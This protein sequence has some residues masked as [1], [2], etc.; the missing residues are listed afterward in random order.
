MATRTRANRR[1][2]FGEENFSEAFLAADYPE[3]RR[4]LSELKDPVRAA[5]LTAKVDFREQRYVEM[6][7]PLAGLKPKDPQ[8]AIERDIL[9]GAAYG[10]TSD[11]TTARLRLDRAIEKAQSGSDL[12]ADALFYKALIAWLEHEHRESEAIAA[13]LTHH[14]SAN[15][16]A[17]A[18][19]LLSWIAVRRRDV[20]RQVRELTNALDIFE[21]TDKPDEYYRAKTLLTLA[22]LG[23]ELPLPDETQRVRQTYSRMQWAAGTRLSQFQTM[24]YMGWIDALE[25]D[26]L[27]AFRAFRAASALAP[28][29]HWRVL[30]LTDRAYL[31]RN[32]GERTFAHDVL[33]EAHEVAQKLSWHETHREERS[34]LFVLAELF[35]TVDPALSQM[36]LAQFRSLNTSVMLGISYD[37]DPRTR[38]FAAYS[39]GKALLELGEK[40]EAIAMLSGAREI[41]DAYHYGWRTALCALALHKATGEATWLLDARRQ[42]APWPHSWIAREVAASGDISAEARLSKAQRAVLDLLLEGKSNVAIAKALGRSPYTVRNHIAQLFRTYDVSN[43]T[44]L[45]GLFRTHKRA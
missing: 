22:L 26:E 45:A 41:F 16:R 30:C 8:L 19:V 35:A 33:H 18:H 28:S 34:S 29:E 1:T 24:R 36:Y 31:A 42:V 6:I 9:L 13:T 12:H 27:A 37:D 2:R 43:R 14:A 11:Y 21:Q 17:R 39:S 25:G 20:D 7:Q 10:H 5:V 44:Q 3:C 15:N 32:T 40:E 23:R 4:L 38:A